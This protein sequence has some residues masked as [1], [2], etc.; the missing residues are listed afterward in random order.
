MQLDGLDFAED[1][2]LVSQTQQQMQEKTTSVAAASATQQRTVGE[3]KPDFSGGR[4]QE[5]AL[6]VDRIHIEESTQMRH[7][8]SFDIESSRPWEKRRPKNTLRWEM[9]MDVR[10][11]NKNEMELEKK[12]HDRVGW[13]M[14]VGG[15]CSS[16]GN[17][18]K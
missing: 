14:L 10:K 15:L 7:K 3:N 6:Y 4:N 16:A 12:A 2:A 17:R 9:E 5:K 1:L 11:M 18:R 13:R 8:A